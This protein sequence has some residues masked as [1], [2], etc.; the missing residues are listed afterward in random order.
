MSRTLQ[1]Y[2]SQMDRD[3][4]EETGGSGRSGSE[5]VHTHKTRRPHKKSRYGCTKCKARRIKCDEGTPRCSRCEKMNLTCQYRNKK[6][7]DSWTEA[8]DFS[9]LEQALPPGEFE[10]L[11]H[12]LEHTSRDP[13]VGEHDKYT[14]QIGIPNL[15]C[16]SKPL[17]RSVLALAATCKCCDIINQTSTP[18]AASDRAQVIELLSLAQRYHS[19]S[20]HEIQATLHEPKNYDHVLANAAMMGMYGSANH[21]VRIWLAKTAPFGEDP[22]L[23]DLTIP[24]NPQWMS[25]FRAVRLAYAGLL[26]NFPQLSPGGSPP[27]LT[28]Q[29]DYKASSRVPPEDSR[30]FTITSHPLGP[31]LG[32]TAG[33]ALARLH[34]KASEVQA[35]IQ[36]SNNISPEFQ[37]CFSALAIFSQIVTDSLLPA[38]SSTPST[39]G[40]GQGH[41]AFPMDIQQVDDEAAERLAEISPWLRKYTASISSTIPSH[42]PRR[43]IMSLVHKVPTPFL[44]LIEEM[45]G[46]IQV[47][48]SACEAMS[49]PSI[50]HQLAVEIF[51]HWLVLVML[52]DN[53]WWIGGIGAWELGRFVSVRRRG[54]WEMC[55]WNKDRDWWPESMFEIGKQ[56]DKHR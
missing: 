15:A 17:M 41:L 33:S 53:V 28:V 55:M 14:L 22:Q 30:T 10:L 36:A 38:D 8:P 31:I 3:D 32:A 2:L 9:W 37:A 4:A 47:D 13:S 25:L 26:K 18:P 34:E 50:A 20:L 12:Y 29:Y 35:M 21:A 6:D 45:I 11:R 46:L 40:Q 56:F 48:E 43:T 5:P 39:P 27:A 24:G 23:F 44:N 16:Q 54:G 52:L 51:A 1:N 19:E 49:A 7:T 42:L